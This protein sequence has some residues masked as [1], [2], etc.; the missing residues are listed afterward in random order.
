MKTL[1]YALTI[2]ALVGALAISAKADLQFLGAVDFNNG[3]N[4]PTANHTAITNFL[5]FD[6]G[7]LSSN[8][9]GSGTL[10]GPV[11]VTPGEYFAV[12]YGK[13]SGGTG[14]GGSLE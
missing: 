1:K 9:Q 13:G 7:T 11:S 12:H 6:P 5:G 8:F 10:S 14:S 4:S 3:P 2:L